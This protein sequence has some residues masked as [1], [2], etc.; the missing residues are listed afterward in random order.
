MAD[1]DRLEIQI[2][3]YAGK[4]NSE[5]DKLARRLEKIEGNLI[6]INASG[7]SNFAAGI[8]KLSQAMQSINSVKT[9]QFTALSKNIQ[10][11]A[12]TD[13]ASI[14]RASTAINTISRSIENAGAAMQSSVNISEM[15]KNIAKL[16]GKNVERAITLLPKLAQ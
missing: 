5:L 13:S 8:E 14:L 4:A 7:L 10:K 16:G 3:S 9:S 11:L 15:A 12:A 1:I 6:R 2:E